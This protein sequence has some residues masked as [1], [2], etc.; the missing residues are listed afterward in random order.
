MYNPDGSLGSS[1]LYIFL[2]L[3]GYS[4]YRQ[5]QGATVATTIRVK[6]FDPSTRAGHITA[7]DGQTYAVTF[8]APRGDSTITCR[9]NKGQI[10]TFGLVGTVDVKQSAVYQAQ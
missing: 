10:W 7:Q 6:H 3:W 9:T 4:N 2:R 5:G 1:G 8:E